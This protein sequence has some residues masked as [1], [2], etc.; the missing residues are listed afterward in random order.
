MR[1]RL[2]LVVLALVGSQ[3]ALAQ[4]QAPEL[5]SGWTAKKP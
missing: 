2:F 3:V 4:D 5:P 1:R